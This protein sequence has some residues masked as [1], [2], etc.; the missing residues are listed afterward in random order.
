MIPPSYGRQVTRP[1]RP[2]GRAETLTEPEGA[3]NHGP[4]LGVLFER[5]ADARPNAVAVDSDGERMTY[6]ALDARANR[7]AH[8]LRRQGAVRGTV[9]GISDGPGLDAVVARL[10]V[11]KAGAA[12]VTV[13]TGGDTA[14]PLV[15]PRFPA[16]V[17][18]VLGRGA[19]PARL[20]G[21]L[22]AGVRLIALDDDAA[23]ISAE[24]DTRP[25]SC[26]SGLDVACLVPRRARDGQALWELV[27]HR[28]VA[29]RLSGP[30]SP[31]PDA[32][33]SWSGTPQPE[34]RGVDRWWA[35]LLRGGTCT[36]ADDTDRAAEPPHEDLWPVHR[37]AGVGGAFVLDSRLRLLPPG[38][39]GDLYLAGEGLG[40]GYGDRPSLSAERFV[41]HPLGASGQ[42]MY[43]TGERARWRYDG[44]VELVPRDAEPLPEL[45]LPASVGGA[46]AAPAA[47]RTSRQEILCGIFADMLGR[48]TVGVHDDFF[49][50]GGH[51]ILAA[52]IAG[53]VRTLFGVELDLSAVFR[54]PTVAQLDAR[55]SRSE[56]VRAVLR[57]VEPRPALLPAS[58][59]QQGLWMVDQIQGPNA[60]YNIPTALRLQ[61]ALDAGA[62]EAAVN[63]VV[64]RH[65]A[66][67]TTFRNHDGAPHQHVVPE[68]EARVHLERSSC[69]HAELPDFLAALAGRPCDLGDGPLIR[70]FLVSLDP[71][72]HVLLLLIHHIVSDGASLDPLLGDLSTA[73]AARREGAAPRWDPLP[74][75]YVDYALWQRELLGS[76]EDPDSVLS[77]QLDFWRGTLAGLPTE[78]DLP[79]ARP[80][81]E[82]P[83]FRG[84]LVPLTV[85][86][87]LHRRLVVLARR[88][89]ATMLM[90]LQTGLAAL[91]SRLGAGTDVPVGTVVSGR[92]DE[93][94]DQLIGFFTNTLV[95]RTDLSGNP[96]ITELLD[97]VRAT[98]LAAFAHQNAPF[99]RLVELL[100]PERAAARHPLFQ[101]ML[102]LQGRGQPQPDWPDVQVV[103]FEVGNETAKFDLSLW[104]REDYV[105]DVPAGLNGSFEF[106]VDLFDRTTVEDLATRFVRV[107]E[108]MATA[109]DT[110]LAQVDLLSAEERQAVLALSGAS[111][112]VPATGRIHELFEARARLHP[113]AIAT[114][115]GDRQLRYGELNA[116]ANRLGRHLVEAGVTRGM[117]VGVCLERG[118]DLA[119]AALAVLKTGAACV[120]LDPTLPA[121]DIA[122][123]LDVT[124]ARHL[125]DRAGDAT[126]VRAGTTVSLDQDAA[127][128]DARS[129][130]NLDI[131]GHFGDPAWATV[132][133]VAAGGKPEVVVASHLAVVGTCAALGH[134]AFGPDD[135]YLPCSPLW[136]QT[137]VTELFGAL[138]HG[139]RCVLDP[140]Q[141]PGPAAVELLVA[142]HG[143]TVLRLPESLFARLL[144][145]R[146]AA[147]GGVRYV[148]TGAQDTW[149]AHLAEALRDFPELRVLSGYGP[150]ENTGLTTCH[151]AVAEASE[152]SP[153]PI[154]VPVTNQRA[155]VLGPGLELVPVGAVGDL[156]VA[157]VGLAL[158]YAHRP[159]LTAERFI[160]NPYGTPGERM[161]RAG[162]LARRRDDGVLELVGPVGGRK[163]APDPGALPDGGA[164]GASAD[165]EDKPRTER[166]ELL[167]ALF[168]EV[169]EA[170]G[171]GVH[172]NFFDLGGHSLLA[173][174]LVVRIRSHL[175]IKASV[176]DVM[177][178]PTV[179]G[180]AERL[181]QAPKVRP[182]RRSTTP[183]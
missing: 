15:P 22:P 39:V 132:T 136:E 97:R 69:R 141:T 60:S 62:L 4:S 83:S 35:A 67:R 122:R 158:G 124:A 76:E 147:L 37:P 30:P 9:V 72:E 45:L 157:G 50:L 116:R 181:E 2:T 19:D 43:R 18:V 52:R 164:P 90:V 165:A 169:L 38:V 58:P 125:V 146:P 47:P 156:Y 89:G 128:I 178:A 81:P 65:E 86:A 152:G 66:L 174:R 134:H 155:Y 25:S 106:S 105:D 148:L 13:D 182:R 154:G 162:R 95:L 179:A 33:R 79:A 1:E 121:E 150:A 163:G 73:Y 144:D 12:Y 21:R 64:V 109:P 55:I 176:G 183:S 149:A 99:E 29:H 57:P 49:D 26:V 84:E 41:A 56:Q 71:D 114:A 172:D 42:R 129:A 153:V 17:G 137:F 68:P 117:S 46:P 91:L 14:Q 23:L 93:A 166:E 108:A 100:N 11:V 74:V 92:T 5:Q 175:G 145:E 36:V 63:D 20:R 80:R 123:V 110:R 118:P 139:A 10:A 151:E 115:H 111:A 85:G 160:A 70:A 28:A 140:G 53:R 82:T 27:P 107:L 120:L 171:V 16:T 51:S 173:S 170:V 8:H 126:G 6:A 94:L 7:L 3:R 98:D 130:A 44:S 103:P 168:E 167:C 54:G 161:Y 40:Y 112:D 59:G 113:D 48:E 75:Q 96:T 78:L 61:G 87:D 88:Q 142:K 24:P 143:V 135:V 102:V 133:A 34:G 159:A 138:L 177:A 31:G 127:A 32:D 77:R 101:T 131:G 180:L 104:L 119:V